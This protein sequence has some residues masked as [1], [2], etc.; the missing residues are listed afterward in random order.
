MATKV[1]I[2]L[3]LIS[4][5]I[6]LCL[7]STTYSRYI[8]GATGNIE[9]FFAKW[10]ILVNEQDITNETNTNLTFTPIIEPNDYVKNKMMAPASK[11]YFDL[12][13]DP[14]NIELSF[15]YTI[16]INLDNIDIPD[17]RAETYTILTN[18]PLTLL[19]IEDNI[20]SNTLHFD[21][22]DPDF[23]FEPFTIR[24]FFEWYEGED[25]LMNDED[26]TIIGQLAATTDLSFTINANLSFIQIFS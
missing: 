5:S 24:I 11:G 25:E 13:L 6:C 20:I 1:Q 23:K 8:A 16:E 26:D 17:L 18:E 3:S 19:P 2:L 12:D 14:T 21:Q 4:L 7:M 10:Q 9:A 15:Q 22:T